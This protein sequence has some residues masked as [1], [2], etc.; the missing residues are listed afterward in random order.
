VPGGF[1]VGFHLTL[2]NGH[3]DSL[4]RGAIMDSSSPVFY[5]AI[6]PPA[7]FEPAY[8][9]LTIWTGCSNSTNSLQCLRGVPTT[10]LVALLNSTG[11]AGFTYPSFDNDMIQRNG[12]QQ[13]TNGSFVR[14]PILTGTN[15]DEG[16]YFA[17]QSPT[18]K[19]ISTDAEFFSFLTNTLHVPSV[20]SQKLA[21]AYP[22]DPAQGIP[23]P[24]AVNATYRPDYPYGSQFR[25][26]AAYL[27]DAD[28]IANRRLT[29]ATW[30]RFNL[31][32][33]SYRFTSIPAGIPS[34]F[35]SSHVLELP[36]AFNNLGAYGWNA[37]NLSP[38]NGT[39][40]QFTIMSQDEGFVDLAKGMSRA[41]ISFVVDQDPNSW[42]AD[43]SWM[44]WP[45]YGEGVG[46]ANGTNFVW[47]KGVNQSYTEGDTFRA[48]GMAMIAA[49]NADIYLR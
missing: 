35:G 18:P 37:A 26:V 24:P 2:F 32:C 25:R 39:A 16:T 38:W 43:P 22:D 40:A 17:S 48:A 28:I 4:F 47:V 31:P 5:R 27:G 6:S 7:F 21:L 19:N 41:W 20:F 30:T 44:H 49:A 23:G 13:L 36:F 33:Y 46:G 34:I 11:L 9:N 3:D 45:K 8:R 29:C 15:S 10:K 1:S 14:V 42:K 12:S